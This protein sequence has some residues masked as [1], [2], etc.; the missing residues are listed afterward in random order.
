[1]PLDL[2]ANDQHAA[3]GLQDGF[4]FD[5]AQA[6]AP[7][8]PALAALWDAFYDDPVIPPE[9][10]NALLHELIALLDSHG[11]TANKALTHTIVR[12]LPFFSMASQG[13]HT[14]RAESD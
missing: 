11:G 8:F 5:L 4:L 3:I 13:G 1:M 10:A 12:L 7:R 2:Y 9:Q 14:I 6:D